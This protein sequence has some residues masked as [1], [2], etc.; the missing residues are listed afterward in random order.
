MK[1]KKLIYAAWVAALIGVFVMIVA[2]GAAARKYHAKSEPKYRHDNSCSYHRDNSDNSID[3]K[4]KHGSIILVNREDD[5]RVE[6]TDD[7]QLFINDKLVRT[8][9]EQTAL[10]KE[11]HETSMEIVE[12]AKAIGLEGAKIGIS[13]AALGL[14]AVGCVFKLLSPNYDGDDLERDMDLA[15]DQIEKRAS[16]L[17]ARAE[18][19][20][21]RADRLSD[22]A[23]EMNE[24]IPELGALGWF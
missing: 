13:G 11:Y 3:W 20:E 14:K 7:Y 4:V 2:P 17:E 1:G 12:E 21:D 10:L 5:S 6:I 9:D 16:K 8:N 18:Q 19:L 23:D 15:S 24:K 22:L